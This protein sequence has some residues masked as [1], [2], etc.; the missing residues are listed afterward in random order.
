[1]HPRLPGQ[2]GGGNPLPPR[3]KPPEGF[4]QGL[5][6]LAPPLP[7]GRLEVGHTLRAGGLE[8]LF[9]GPLK[10]LPLRSPCPDLSLSGPF[11]EL[12]L[13][14]AFQGLGYLAEGRLA[15][16]VDGGRVSAYLKKVRR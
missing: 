3:L 7:V 9:P 2:G 16:R 12:H 14:A 4:H 10:L 1:V 13:K 6:R 5:F 11:G 8:A 15:H